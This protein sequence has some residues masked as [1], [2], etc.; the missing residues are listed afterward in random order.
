MRGISKTKQFA[1]FWLI[2]L[3]LYSCS[4]KTS[5]LVVSKESSKLDTHESSKPNIQ[6]PLSK[7]LNDLGKKYI[8]EFHLTLDSINL[9]LRWDSIGIDLEEKKINLWIEYDDA[10]V[11]IIQSN[12]ILNS[13][14]SGIKK[15]ISSRFELIEFL[16]TIVDPKFY[17]KFTELESN[18]IFPENLNISSL[19]ENSNLSMII[20]L[21]QYRE[22]KNVT[23]FSEIRSR[24]T[25]TPICTFDDYEIQFDEIPKSDINQ[26]ELLIIKQNLEK[27]FK[28]DLNKNEIQNIIEEINKLITN[29]PDSINKDIENRRIN[30]IKTLVSKPPGD[31]NRTEMLIPEEIRYKIDPD[32]IDEVTSYNIN[33]FNH[34]EITLQNSIEMIYIPEG[35]FIMGGKK[36]ISTRPQRKVHLDAYWIGKYEITREQFFK[37]L[38]LEGISEKTKV[39]TNFSKTNYMPVVMVSWHEA[40]DFCEWLSDRLGA[41]FRLPTEAEWEKAARGTDARIY[42]WGNMEPNPQYANF[43]NKSIQLMNVGSFPSGMSPYGVYDIAG[44]VWEWCYDNYEERYRRNSTAKKLQS[45]GDS[46]YKVCRGGSWSNYIPPIYYRKK[47]QPQ[48]LENDLGFRIVMVNN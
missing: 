18:V 48:T 16:D 9:D 43:N 31:K 37:F 38:K 29:F 39:I 33:E 24:I 32:I 8:N 2:I 27:I 45:T 35:D 46:K 30:T 20:K 17:G 12:Y 23:I 13:L 4:Q 5:P 21:T 34:L 7:R 44:N 41:N 1:I 11:N 36:F 26:S 14:V 10:D 28:G 6:E 40:E 3:V 19:K 42:P 47:L 25:E 15:E 22:N